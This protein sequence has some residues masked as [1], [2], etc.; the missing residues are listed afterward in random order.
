MLGEATLGDLVQRIGD[1]GVAQI[2]HFSELLVRSWVAQLWFS[3]LVLIPLVLM[4]LGLAE[5]LRRGQSLLLGWYVIGYLGIYS[6]WPFEEGV[7]YVFPIFPFLFLFAW[8]GARLV[9]CAAAVAGPGRLRGVPLV[10]G[11]ITTAASWSYFRLDNGGLQGDLAVGFWV[12]ALIGSWTVSAPRFLGQFRP[13]PGIGNAAFAIVFS[14]AVAVGLVQQSVI[15]A[16]NVHPDASQLPHQRTLE[17]ARWLEGQPQRG[18]VMAQQLAILH[19]LT[20]RRIVGFPITSDGEL[21]ADTARRHQVAYLVVGDPGELDYYPLE[22]DRLEA[23][24]ATEPDCC[25]LAHVGNGF[26]IYRLALDP[27]SK[28]PPLDHEQPER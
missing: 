9:F 10:I 13:T 2:A 24:L 5:S 25:R 3:P 7:R 8:R 28:Q 27:A 4:A 14:L 16:A 12:V 17:A 11:L 20:G 21:I 23:L 15:A 19:R 18:P 1:F 6:L 26:R 22:Q